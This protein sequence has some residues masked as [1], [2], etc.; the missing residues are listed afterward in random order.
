V[1]KGGVLVTGGSGF[2]GGHLIERLLEE[3]YKVYALDSQPH[4]NKRGKL[5][6][7]QIDIADK[8]QL[9]KLCKDLY[10]QVE[11][12]VHLAAVGNQPGISEKLYQTVNVDGT[13]NVF[14][15]THTLACP[16]FMFASSVDAVGPVPKDCLPLNEL[17][18]CHPINPYGRSKLEAERKILELSSKLNIKACILRFGNVYG[19][20]SLSFIKYIADAL[21]KRDM[22][23]LTLTHDIN[24]WHPV[25]V[26]DLIDAITRVIKKEHFYN[27]VY[28]ITGH[29]QPTNG[30]LTEIIAKEL[31]YTLEEFR[32]N[33]QGRVTFLFRQMLSFLIRGSLAKRKLY[34]VYSNHKAVSEID[35]APTVSLEEGIPKVISWAK[36]QNIL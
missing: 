4:N 10:E 6:S 13:I 19:I 31:G 20:N 18:T 36:E 22:Y 9:E 12:V 16:Y 27:Q 23:F 34:K 8:T 3:D 14:K 25:F 30:Y 17:A 28:Y 24:M 7:L 15:M 26:D 32:T 5:I 11:V 21:K 1:G 29:E 33:L 2:I 35:F